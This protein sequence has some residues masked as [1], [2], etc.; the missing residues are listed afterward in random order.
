MLRESQNNPTPYIIDNGYVIDVDGDD[1]PTVG[2]VAG[3]GNEWVDVNTEVYLGD[4]H[5]AARSPYV[6]LL[7]YSP[8]STADS[9]ILKL[10]G[11]AHPNSRHLGRE[12][13]SRNG[14]VGHPHS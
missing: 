1:N 13:T 14:T 12:K 6:P 10:E 3:D 11:E 9:S 7:L 5:N 2:G 8:I 4:L